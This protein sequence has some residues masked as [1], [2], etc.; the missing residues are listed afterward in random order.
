MCKFGLYTKNFQTNNGYDVFTYPAGEMQVRLTAETVAYFSALEQDPFVGVIARL[1]TPADIIELVLLLDAIKGMELYP[2]VI[3]PYHPYSRADRRFMPGDC[4]GIQA[5]LSMLDSSV[6]TLDKHSRTG[7]AYGVSPTEFIRAAIAHCAIRNDSKEVLVLLP[8]EGAA[9]RYKPLLKAVVGNNSSDVNVTAAF[10]KKVR[11]VESGKLT[12]FTVPENLPNV[13]I[14]I[15]DDICDGGGTFIG[16]AAELRKRGLK[17]SLYTTHSM[18]SKG[19][20]VLYDAGFEYLYTTNSFYRRDKTTPD[21]MVVYDCVPLL[22][23]Y[24]YLL[25]DK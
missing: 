7:L 9:K 18:Y 4:C 25:G 1:Y 15:V 3:L 11:D 21:K 22:L 10:C 8:D 19:T 14:L 17:Y 5:F 23:K 6:T 24:I 2:K 16:I 12:G 13:P 20:D